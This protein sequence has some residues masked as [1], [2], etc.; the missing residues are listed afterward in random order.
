MGVLGSTPRA[1]LTLAVA[2]SAACGDH[3]A[4]AAGATPATAPAVDPALAEPA[5]A[6]GQRLREAARAGA[7]AHLP[8]GVYFRDRLARAEGRDFLVVLKGVHCYRIVAI[9]DPGVEDLD[10]VIHDPAGVRW[11]QDLTQD[12]NPVLGVD[13]ELCPPESGAYRLHV[14][15]AAGQGEFLA[16]V[17]RSP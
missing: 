17:Y 1:T 12:A 5:D 6:M 7:S 14:R 16:G 4:P 13:A 15:M 3:G 9:G 10:L 11:R 8:V 2:I